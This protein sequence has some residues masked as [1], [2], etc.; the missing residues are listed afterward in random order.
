[1][2]T[3]TVCCGKG[4]VGKTFSTL[5]IATELSIKSKSKK[6]ILIVDLDPSINTSIRISNQDSYEYTIADL[7]EDQSLDPKKAIYPT[8]ENFP[9]IFVMAGSDRLD[10]VDQL[11]SKRKNQDSILKRI[12]KQIELDFDIVLIDCP[13]SRGSLVA[14]A[15]VACNAYITP[16]GLDDASIDGVLAIHRLLDELINEEVLEKLPINLGAF[17]TNYEKNSSRATRH[18]IELA[19]EYL[20]GSLLPIRIPGTS[21]VREAISHQST[22]Q[23]DR[24]HKV[25]LAYQDLTAHI[26]KKAQLRGYSNGNA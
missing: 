8:N 16:F 5:S 26:V 12:L 3:I 4:G 21:H 10:F 25:S 15:L 7:F 2:K 13:P 17:C 14:N 20:K 6:K 9:G 1:M 23:F 18:V 24:D 11:I 19:N 22:L